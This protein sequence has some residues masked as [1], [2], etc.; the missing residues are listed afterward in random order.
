MISR[1]FVQPFPLARAHSSRF[2]ANFSSGSQF[3]GRARE[4]KCAEDIA[5]DRS[6]DDSLSE[7][8]RAESR[9]HEDDLDDDLTRILPT[10]P[11]LGIAVARF[12]S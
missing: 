12:V 3:R 6:R 2:L 4:T 9:P 1:T 10:P 5:S 8:A 7:S 11:A